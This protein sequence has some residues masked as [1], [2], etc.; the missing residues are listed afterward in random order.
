MSSLACTWKEHLVFSKCLVRTG[1]EDLSSSAPFDWYGLGGEWT[2]I[3]LETI[4]GNIDY[5]NSMDAQETTEKKGSGKPL[6]EGYVCK[7]C[8]STE[9]AIYN[10]ALYKPKKQKIRKCKFFTWRLSH[11]ITTE[12][13]QEWLVENGIIGAIDVSLVTDKVKNECKGVGFITV[14][15]S[16]SEALLAL[17]GAQLDGKL[18]NIKIDEKPVEKKREASSGKRRCYRCGGDHEPVDC[19]NDRVCY[20]C[21]LSDHLS[22]DCPN[23]KRRTQK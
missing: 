11:S 21:G 16:Q 5:H 17:N 15:A 9:H 4:V 7:A 18:F 3:L 1:M 10:C 2:L 23:K 20:K 6:P 8:G 22:S 19:T 12:A 13:I 14:E